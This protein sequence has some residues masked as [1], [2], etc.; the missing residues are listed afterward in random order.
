MNF[1]K[2]I[3]LGRVASDIEMRSTT[4]GQSVC[5][6]RL[7][8][9]RIWKDKSGERKEDSQFHNIVLWGKQA[10]NASQ[11]MTKGSLVLIEGRLQNRSWE[12]KTGNKRYITEIIGENFQLGPRSGGD[13]TAKM[14]INKEKNK[15]VDED[16]P[17]IEDGDEIDI[18]DIPF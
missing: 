18:K 6:F 17:V 9:N 14:P 7:A 5:T 2:I 11:F 4:T 16:I 12:D 1:N 15:E 3:L 13:G 8:T 10:E